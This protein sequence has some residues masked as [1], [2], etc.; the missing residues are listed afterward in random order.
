MRVVKLEAKFLTDRGQ[1]R[2]HNEDAGGV[3]YNKSGQLLTVIADGMGGHKAGDI[4]SQL[5]VSLIEEKWL[6]ETEVTSP[7]QTE[8]W[9]TDTIAA[10]NVTIYERSLE[11]ENFNSMGTTIVTAIVTD[12]Y[13]TVAHIGDSRCYIYNENGFTQ[14][15]EDHS[16]VN[17]LMRSGQ[18]SKT[19]AK[20]HPRKNIVLKAL[21]TEQEE[22]ADV[23]TLSWETGNKLLLCS[24]GLTDKLMDDELAKFIAQAEQVETIGQKMIDLAN[25]RG[26]EDN[27]S[28]VIVSYPPHDESGDHGC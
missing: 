25:E 12:D 11:H 27:I 26:G 4:A 1:I 16:L 3:F 9:L 5:A 18:I 17:E 19:D 28:L 6:T 22:L 24:D 15:T 8:K 10:L 7:E 20:N 13:V 21:G 2:T 23:Q 14:V